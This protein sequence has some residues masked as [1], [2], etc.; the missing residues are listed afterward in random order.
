M[1]LTHRPARKRDF[2]ACLNLL[3]DGF[4]LS[5][6]RWLFDRLSQTWETLLNGESMVLS[7]IEDEERPTPERIVGFGATVFVSDEFAAYMRSGAAPYTYVELVRRLVDGR[8]SILSAEEIR[9]ANSG[10]GLNLFVLHVEWAGAILDADEVRHVR[11]EILTAFLGMLAGYRLKQILVEPIGFE[12]LPWA[13]AAGFRERTRFDDYFSHSPQRP[14]P[15]HHPYL[16][17]ITR[18]EAETGEVGA[19]LR[20]FLYTEPRLFFAPPRQKILQLAILDKTDEEIAAALGISRE[21]V[22]KA[23]SAIYM[24]AEDAVATWKGEIAPDLLVFRNSTSNPAGPN[25]TDLA[26]R[27]AEKKRLLLRYLRHHPEELRPNRK[28]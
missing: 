24:T 10:S 2:Q 4:T 7:V 28:K 26:T 12:F 23:W 17:G 21:T 11:E 16:V 13:C 1:H 25:R 3:C 14:D 15:A 8:S 27:G 20:F 18:E 19:L 22:R 5:G 9:D 6:N